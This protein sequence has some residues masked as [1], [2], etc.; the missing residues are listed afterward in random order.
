M[1]DRRAL[2]EERFTQLCKLE[3]RLASLREQAKAVDGSGE[4]FCANMVW[5]RKLKPQLLE[6][7]GWEAEG[8]AKT[9]ELGSNDAYDA[10]YDL[11]YDELPDC[12]DCSCVRMGDFA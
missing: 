11:I 6:L 8:K 9:P 7:V 3:P 12:K 5:Y 10:A 4:H 2:N 1:N